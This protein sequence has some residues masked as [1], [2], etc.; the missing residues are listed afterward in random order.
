[1]SL[2]EYITRREEEDGINELDAKRRDENLRHC[3]NYVFEY[4]NNCLVTTTEDQLTP[5]LQKKVDKYK[6]TLTRYS[7][8]IEDWL[9][10]LFIANGKQLDK[11]LRNTI[12]RHPYFILYDSE[13]E[14]RELSYDFYSELKK[15]FPFLDGQAEM[16]FQFIKDYHRAQ[17]VIEEDDKDIYINEK[18]SNW[19]QN[20]HKNYGVNVIS[21]CANWL[22]YYMNNPRLWPSQYKS[23]HDK[24]MYEWEKKNNSS[25]RPYD[26]FHWDYKYRSNSNLFNIRQLYYDMPK[27][28]FTNRKKKYFEAIMLYI[29]LNIWGFDDD[30]NPYWPEYLKM[31]FPEDC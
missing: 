15:R 21:F 20:T 14:L 23:I 3:V 22:G 16:L 11:P 8:E 29:Y 24:E 27:K 5:V 18:V 31:T 2:G 26:P 10:A 4:F 9:V 12:D 1:M 19:V 13:A 30:T 6:L 7:P 28:P 17:N 25:F